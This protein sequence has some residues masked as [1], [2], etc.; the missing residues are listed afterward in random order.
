MADT[1][2]YLYDSKNRGPKFSGHKELIAFCDAPDGLALDQSAISSTEQV[3]ITGDTTNT[4]V[5]T[6]SGDT[7]PGFLDLNEYENVTLYAWNG[8]DGEVLTLKIYTA[9]VQDTVANKAAAYAAGFPV[10][11][12]AATSGPYGWG[13][14]GA[15]IT[16]A[17]QTACAPQKISST[18]GLIAVTATG[19][20]GFETADEV[21]I[22]LVGERA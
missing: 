14:E 9:P 10:H 6:A 7:Q 1:V 18:G 4:Y 15:A 8:S 12:A 19:D 2:C 5:N 11:Y 3:M 22:W 20:A 16:V 17:T 13:L 21:K